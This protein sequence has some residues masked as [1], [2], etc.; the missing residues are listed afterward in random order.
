MGVLG[1]TKG[2]RMADHHLR[3]LRARR[4]RV[5]PLQGPGGEA[6][7]FALGK[8]YP[9]IGGQLDVLFLKRDR[10][11]PGALGLRL[12]ELEARV[13][14]GI[15]SVASPIL[16][17]SERELDRAFRSQGF[18]WIERRT[19]ERDLRSPLG[20]PPQLPEGISIRSVRRADFAAI[21]RRGSRAYVRH[22]DAA[23]GP[24]ADPLRWGPPYLRHLLAGEAHF[25]LRC[26]SSFLALDS[27]GRIVGTSLVVG[28]RARHIQELSVDPEWQRRGIG[29]ALLRAS[30]GALQ[31][32]GVARVRIGVTRLNPTG[33]YDLYR[34]EGFRP[35]A[36]RGQ[37][38]GGAWVKETTR[39]ALGLRVL[40][41]R[42]AAVPTRSRPS[43]R[44]GTLRGP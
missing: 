32:E 4:A 17:G 5:L 3:Q 1:G 42:E 22:I 44:H 14:E 33:A 40:G 28:E 25:P 20:T 34:R 9:G 27:G 2:R 8:W 10:R 23:F 38:P 35:V 12:R 21:A 6:V 15:F 43:P 16:A 29:R 19:L 41:E 13:P 31:R 39:R 30:C 37:R 18:R 24:G 7:G 36:R 11:R 26:S